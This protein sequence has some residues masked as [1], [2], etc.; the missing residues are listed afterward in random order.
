MDL[1][2]GTIA[3]A[4]THCPQDNTCFRNVG[5]SRGSLGAARKTNFI[6]TRPS[7]GDGPD[8]RFAHPKFLRNRAVGGHR[9]SI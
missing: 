1:W 3:I 2:R 6:N 5:W 4:E 9:E 7:F 8:P